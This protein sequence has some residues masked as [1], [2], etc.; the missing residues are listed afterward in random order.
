MDIK[1]RWVIILARPQKDIAIFPVSKA[2]YLSYGPQGEIREG[3]HYPAFPP[4]TLEYP[5]TRNE[6][7]DAIKRGIDL[8]DVYECYEDGQGNHKTFEEVFYGVKGFRKASKGI[9]YIR[10]LCASPSSFEFENTVSLSLPTKSGYAYL[11]I[12]KTVLESG[13][14]WLD[15][16]DVI[17]KYANTDLEEFRSFKTFKRK[18]NL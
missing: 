17:Y 4:I 5:Y 18:L 16:A 2:T 9:R 7:A 1:V 10:F 14:D 8:W 12:N 13:A 6:L 11:A 3:I 15:F